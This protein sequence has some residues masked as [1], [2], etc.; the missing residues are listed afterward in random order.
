MI[1]KHFFILG[2]LLLFLVTH[3]HLFFNNDNN[4]INDDNND[5][6][7]KFLLNFTQNMKNLNLS[8]YKDNNNNNIQD[9]DAITPSSYDKL[10]PPSNENEKNKNKRS[11]IRD[12]YDARTGNLLLSTKGELRLYPNAEEIPPSC[13]FGKLHFNANGEMWTCVCSEPDYFGG[14]YCDEP[15]KKLILKNKCIKVGRINDLENTD[16]STFNPFTQGV[17]VECSSKDATPNFSSP[18]PSCH[19]INT[20]R[21]EE[22]EEEEEEDVCFR[23]VV[24]P[25]F[26]S[27]FN[28]YIKGYGCSCDYYNGFVEVNVGDMGD[29]ESA[30]NSNGCL[31]IGKSPSG[32]DYYHKTHIAFHT[33]K[34]GGYPKQVHEYRQLEQPYQSLLF[35]GKQKPLA[36]LIDQPARDIVHKEDWLNRCIKPS[37]EQKISRLNDNDKWDIVHRTG[38][39]RINKYEKRKYTHP[40]SAFTL[41]FHDYFMPKVWTETTNQRYVKN[42]MLGHPVIFGHFTAENKKWR[43][44]CTLNPLGTREK[45]YYGM[46]MLYKPGKIVK[47]DTRGFEKNEKMTIIVIPPDHKKEMMT[48]KDLKLG[49]ILSLKKC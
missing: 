26:N 20:I 17:C 16:I 37:K 7:K 11:L 22:E 41:N 8:N 19:V 42:A 46:T 9:K 12:I 35:G 28:K 38:L 4:I 24:N 30:D 32:G 34:N 45:K 48:Q 36:L 15:Q 5:K 23:D 14:I 2:L 25:N 27:I 6:R 31:K 33:L 10:F 40:I 39:F 1:T 18:F 47:L 44:K 3:F 43:N 21:E 13:G 49:R 29:Q